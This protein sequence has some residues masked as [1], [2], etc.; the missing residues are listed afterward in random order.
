MRIDIQL[1]SGAPFGH[2][3]NSPDKRIALLPASAD[4][5]AV[6]GGD[7]LQRNLFGAGSGALAYVGAAAEVLKVHLRDHVDGAVI[8]F[9]LALW[10]NAQVGNLGSGKQRS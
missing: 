5:V 9:R 2:R 7:H 8:P 10:Q 6:Q 1:R 4:V 3:S